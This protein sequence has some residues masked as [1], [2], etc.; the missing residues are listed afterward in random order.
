M[1]IVVVVVL[2]V[3]RTRYLYILWG[4]KKMIVDGAIV[5]KEIKCY[6]LG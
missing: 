6:I 2:L 4:V 5:V 1:I 3:V